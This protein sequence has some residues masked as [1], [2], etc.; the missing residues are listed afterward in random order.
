[1]KQHNITVKLTLAALP[2]IASLS[3][4][5]DCSQ[6]ETARQLRKESL[7]FL[8]IT[9]IELDQ[10]PQNPSKEKNGDRLDTNS[11]QV[12]AIDKSIPPYFHLI[13]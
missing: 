11:N 7:D 5:A 2:L 9:A 10:S 12:Y 6:P 8:H 1:M 3:A 4:T 13:Q